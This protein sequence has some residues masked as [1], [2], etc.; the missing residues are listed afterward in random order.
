MPS[1]VLRRHRRHQLLTRL[2]ALE[3][4]QLETSSSN[5]PLAVKPC[6]RSRE[7]SRP[8]SLPNRVTT[9]R[10][11]A[12]RKRRALGPYARTLTRR[13]STA[14]LHAGTLVSSSRR[15]GSPPPRPA[16]GLAGLKTRDVAAQTL[17]QFAPTTAL[18]QSPTCWV[19][20]MFALTEPGKTLRD[21]ER[22]RNGEPSPSRKRRVSRHV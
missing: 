3:A 9:D 16:Q 20:P 19:D 6:T 5:M 8:T 2:A 12:S 13:G 1:V 21:S 11:G 10:R 17:R 14:R 18:A 4:S 7:R 22:R 15:G